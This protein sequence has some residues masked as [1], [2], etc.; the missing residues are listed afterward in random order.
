MGIFDS[1]DHLFNYFEEL[2]VDRNFLNLHNHIKKNL[3]F[4]QR[5]K[6]NSKDRTYKYESLSY[7]FFVNKR[8]VRFSCTKGTIPNFDCYFKY[9]ETYISHVFNRSRRLTK[10]T[11]YLPLKIIYNLELND[12]VSIGT[13]QY[14]INSLKTDLLNGK[15]SIE[16]LNVV[17]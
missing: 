13:Q 17:S 3:E 7:D 16:L 6:T 15:S 11:A 1:K 5:N 14:I 4:D 10:V 2:N 12:K 8:R 9:Y